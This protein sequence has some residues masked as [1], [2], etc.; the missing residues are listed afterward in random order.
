MLKILKMT[1]LWAG[2]TA[3]LAGL[4]CCLVVGSGVAEAYSGTINQALNITTSEIVN[5]DPDPNEDTTY[6]K[7][8]FGDFNEA[9]LEKLRAATREQ[10]VN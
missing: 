3:I 9:N 7:S 1:R 2:L 8:M 6:Y 10:V 4:L 5:S